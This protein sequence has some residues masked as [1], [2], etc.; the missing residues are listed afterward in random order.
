MFTYKTKQE[1]IEAGDRFEREEYWATVRSIAKQALDEHPDDEEAQHD[2]VWQSV[3]GNGYIIYTAENLKVLRFTEN[4]EA[5]LDYG[6]IPDDKDAY[7]LYAYLAFAAM[8]ADVMDEL[9]R[10][11]DERSERAS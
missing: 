2:D 5:Y 10:L 11:H 8:R 1:V 7:E 9:A 4:D 3:D 6:E